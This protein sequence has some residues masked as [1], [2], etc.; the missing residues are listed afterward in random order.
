[1]SPVQKQNQH[2]CRPLLREPGRRSRK[3][4]VTL[5]A[6]AGGGNA[7]GGGSIMFPVQ[8]CE[9]WDVTKSANPGEME[10]VWEGD[11]EAGVTRELAYGVEVYTPCWRLAPLVVLLVHLVEH[12]DEHLFLHGT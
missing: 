9:T 8:A 12:S 3:Y 6:Q 4:E 7:G 10:L 5:S 11:V 1:M 2:T